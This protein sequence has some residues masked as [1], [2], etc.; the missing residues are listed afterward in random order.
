MHPEAETIDAEKTTLHPALHRTGMLLSIAAAGYLVWM[1]IDTRPWEIGIDVTGMLFPLALA[2]VI[3]AALGCLIGLV[4]H[5]MLHMFA[6]DTLPRHRCVSIYA[7]SQIAKYLPT[8]TLHFVG[9]VALGRTAGIPMQPLLASMTLEQVIVLCVAGLLGV[10]GLPAL[11]EQV[12]PQLVSQASGWVY[13]STVLVLA[14]LGV[15]A[16]H[17]LKALASSLSAPPLI[18]AALLIALF[19]AAVAGLFIFIGNSVLSTGH[20]MPPFWDT[21]SA[22]ALAWAV[23]M[24]FPGASAGIGV[25]E[26]VLISALAAHMPPEAC[27]MAAVTLRLMTVCGDVGL[28]GAAMLIRDRKS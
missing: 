28:Y 18:R 16:R 21:L 14:G 7:L 3:Y 8:N 6:P 9:R 22:L 20:S 13:A 11:M 24:V 4:W 26:L 17:K 2:S 1:F 23:G 12:L 15:L 5:E 19:Y 25:R 27:L 10:A